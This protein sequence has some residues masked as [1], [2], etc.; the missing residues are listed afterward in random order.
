MVAFP[1][2]IDN[3]GKCSAPIDQFLKMNLCF[4]GVWPHSDLSQ[5]AIAHHSVDSVVEETSKTEWLK[6]I[7]PV[8]KRVTEMTKP[9]R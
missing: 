8:K 2:F 1:V 3:I 4:T 5:N 9:E 6:S 7:V